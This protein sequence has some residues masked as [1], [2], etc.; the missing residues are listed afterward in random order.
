MS[1]SDFCHQI[2]QY[3]KQNTPF[4]FMVDFEKKAPLVFPIA[5]CEKE[6]I[7]FHFHAPKKAHQNIDLEISPIS[8]HTYK[9]AFEQVSK[10]IHLGNSFLCNLTFP[11]AISTAHNLDSIYHRAQAMYKLKYKDEFVVFS[12]ESF[13][14]IKNNTISTFPMKGTI[15][16]AVPNAEQQLMNNKKE[17][18]EHNT[19]VDLMRNDL[20]MIAQEVEV[21]RF[22]YI[23]KINTFRGTML[24]TSS[25][26]SGQLAADWPQNF[27]AML[28]KLLPA[29]SISGAPKDK[30]VALIQQ[31]E[32]EPRG[33]YTGVFGT[34][35][36]GEVD[37][38]VAIRYVEK[39]QNGLHYRSGGGI[40]FL[41]KMEEEYDEMLKKVYIPTR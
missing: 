21:K 36:D 6:G 26:I 5:H 31:A 1:E 37:S 39:K 3:I 20:S 18:W 34:Y 16:A 24:Q 22:R 27:G 38:A 9:A 13:I 12:P 7:S 30:T 19:I 23:S 2:Q 17:L 40:T 11:N 15:M 28:L 29:G 14:R 41:S 10:G 35:I 33:Y 4:F 25:E 8:K 32:I